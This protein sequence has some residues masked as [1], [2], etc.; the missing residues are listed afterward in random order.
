MATKKK[1]EEP[2]AEE[3]EEEKFGFSPEDIRNYRMTF[4]A[5]CREGI[6]PKSM[7]DTIKD[8][9]GNEVIMAWAYYTLE[10]WETCVIWKPQS[11]T[12]QIQPELD[13]SNKS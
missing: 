7:T 13:E 3:E 10:F 2:K 4:D 5:K 12:Y 6:L 11:R 1:A 8:P 9:R